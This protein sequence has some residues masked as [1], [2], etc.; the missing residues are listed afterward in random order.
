MFPHLIN[1]FSEGRAGDIFAK[2]RDMHKNTSEHT[3]GDE[4]DAKQ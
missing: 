3:H 4:M 1:V 2:K